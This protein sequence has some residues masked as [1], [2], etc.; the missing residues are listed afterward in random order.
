MSDIYS[1]NCLGTLSSSL[2]DAWAVCHEIAARV[3]GDPGCVPFQG[4]PR[5]A[6]AERPNCIAVLETSGWAKADEEAKRAFRTALD[7]LAAAGV[8]LIDRRSSKRVERLEQ[9][10][11][12][13]REISRLICAYEAL[14]PFGEL[15]QRKVPGLSKAM[16]ERVADGRKVSADEYIV[17]LGLR[18]EMRAAL[19]AL[20]GEVDG[21]AT[22][23]SLG[24][25]PVGLESSGDAVFNVPFTALG[26]PV[27]SLPLLKAAG[28]PVGFQLAGFPQRERALSAMAGFILKTAV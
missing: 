5:P 1:Q 28:L 6:P 24:P 22:L 15:D 27:L 9:T 14:W 8:K 16:Q 13:A 2:E 12:D 18:E 4:G 10:I 25:A 23:S 11:V 3:G 21:F 20:A 26:V 7:R 19:R 17:L